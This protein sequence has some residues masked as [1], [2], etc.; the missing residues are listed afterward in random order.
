MNCAMITCWDSEATGIRVVT[1][2][3]GRCVRGYFKRLGRICQLD[4]LLAQLHKK[5]TGFPPFSRRTSAL[6]GAMGGALP[7]CGSDPLAH[8]A[9][10]ASSPPTVVID[11]AAV[12]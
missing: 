8:S 12:Q 11:H 5:E 1:P 9:D 6:P 4:V 10:R 2:S 7:N 3:P